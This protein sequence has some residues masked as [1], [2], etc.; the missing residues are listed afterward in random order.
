MPK[1]IKERVPTPERPPEERVRDFKEVNLGYT[2]ELAL[3]EAE[4]CLQ[5]PK[6]YA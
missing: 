1:L 6:D 3:K 5:C 4:R 2:W